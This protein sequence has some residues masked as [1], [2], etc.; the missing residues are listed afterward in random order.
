VSVVT[1]RTV[2]TSGGDLSVID[3]GEGPAVLLLHGFPLSSFLWRRFIPL[4]AARFRVIAPDLL[5]AG[6][7]DKPL[8]APLDIRAQAG[9]VRDMLDALEIGQFGVVAHGDGGGVAQRLTLDGAGVS[10]LVLIDTVAFGYW[11][12]GVVISTD[13]DAAAPALVERM[14]VEGIGEGRV[15]DPD[16]LAEYARPFA[17][18]EGMAVYTRAALA[19]D[20]EGLAGHEPEFA[21]WDFPVLLLWGED[22]PFYPVT[23]AE[24]LNEAIPASTLALLPG[25]GHFL[26]EEAPDT[27]V[28]LIMEY[29]RARYL[30]APHAHADSAGD[31]KEGV[32]MLQL[33]R[34]PP[35]LDLEEDE[36]DDWFDVD[37]P[38]GDAGPSPSPTEAS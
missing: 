22:D 23:L 16:V 15:I 2:R 9:Y 1:K 18:A 19:L 29:L 33:E 7:S 31:M 24:R 37:E 34:R 32:V 4:L 17:G 11:P 13:D 38:D 20:G 3:V 36:K 28:P 26:P 12:N 35:W 10:A 14:L 6:D 21:A 25:C 27:I 5:G 30:R 8:D